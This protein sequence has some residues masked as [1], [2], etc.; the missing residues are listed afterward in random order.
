MCVWFS[1]AETVQALTCAHVY[2][3]PRRQFLCSEADFGCNR[4][5]GGCK[6]PLGGLRVFAS[7]CDA[8]CIS[9]TRDSGMWRRRAAR[10]RWMQSKPRLSPPESHLKL[11]SLQL[12]W[13]RLAFLIRSSGA[14]TSAN[15]R[16]TLVW[17]RLSWILSQ[18]HVSGCPLVNC[19]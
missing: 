5:T 14:K 13:T 11:V 15:F 3:A 4:L 2:T 1:S 12:V 7:C 19:D 17:F 8:S 10:L 6:A 9:C 18:G 16:S